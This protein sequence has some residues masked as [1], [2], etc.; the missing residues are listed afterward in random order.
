MDLEPS[1]EPPPSINSVYLLEKI[2]HSSNNTR[3]GRVVIGSVNNASVPS[4]IELDSHANMVV[5]GKHCLC[6]TPQ[7]K[8]MARV[9]A[10]SPTLEPMD[11]PIVDACIRWTDPLTD[12]NHF[13]L[14][15]DALYVEQMEH[16]LIPPFLLRES[17]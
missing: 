12:K 11:I 4:R 7:G 13:L 17:G 6:L 3:P 1:D 9:A 14:F 8:K 16:K 2:R 15:E 10:F 5:L